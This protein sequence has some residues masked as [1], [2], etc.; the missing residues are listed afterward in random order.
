M[1]IHVRQGI[2]ILIYNADRFLRAAKRRKLINDID[3]KS[4]DEALN[5]SISNTQTK[6]FYRR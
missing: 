4:L 3:P 1:A 2:T 6:H 5:F